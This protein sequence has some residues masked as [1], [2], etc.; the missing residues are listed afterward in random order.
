MSA[1]GEGSHAY[2]PDILREGHMVQEFL[3]PK[4]GAVSALY[5]RTPHGKVEISG[6][7]ILLNKGLRIS[8]NTY[9]NS[10]YEDYWH[11]YTSLKDARL[12]LQFRGSVHVEVFRDTG[13]TGCHKVKEKSVAS[14][15]G[16]VSLKLPVFAVRRT[17]RIFISLFAEE[18]SEIYYMGIRTDDPPVRKAKLTFGICTYNREE[19]LFNNLSRLSR[20]PDFD[21][22]IAKIIIVNQ[23]EAF[24]H[25]GLKALI[26]QNP[27]IQCVTQD[28]MGGCGGF[29][30]T[31]YESLNIAEA[32]YHVLMDDDIQ[33]D[34]GIITNLSAFIAYLN[35]E[36]VVGGHMLDLLK[37]WLL[38]EA[39]TMLM[40]NAKTAQL[41]RNIDLRGPDSLAPFNCALEDDYAAWWFCAVPMKHLRAAG[42]PA[43]I[44][45]RGDDIEYGV[46]LQKIGVP[47]V[48]LPGI[49]VWHEPFYAKKSKWKTYY[50]FRNRL[51]MASV[52]K[53]RFKML[54]PTYFLWIMLK[55]MAVN[56]YQKAALIQM[57]LH[58]F[59]K[60]PKLFESETS[61]QIHERVL[62]VNNKYKQ[63]IVE[64]K[65]GEIY[66]LRGHKPKLLTALFSRCFQTSFAYRKDLHKVA[67]AWNRQ[68]HRFRR[69][70]WWEKYFNRTDRQ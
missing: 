45:I 7:T 15:G 40:E 5:L 59:M 13:E 30:R 47:T 65:A 55:Y 46:R 20:Y 11:K 63:K 17:G 31:I 49:A 70:D 51:I 69:E 52:Y 44:F 41:H 33:I 34:P 37:P 60:G 32:N 62:R 9:F 8:T 19:Y 26:S 2:C 66:L 3:L 57:A 64:K 22:N 25:P 68:I 23:G 61:M 29:T 36:I 58:D 48:G 67:L 35:N 43:P 18:D 56:N 1:F 21:N 10:F 54:E 53:G 38:H 50:H 16:V 14:S 28:N 42:Y 24:R 39:G 4:G 27:L 6:H 12:V